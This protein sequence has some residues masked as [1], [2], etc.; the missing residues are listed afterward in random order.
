VADELPGVEVV[1]ALVGPV[2]L[3]QAEMADEV[4]TA[5]AATVVE[6]QGAAEVVLLAG[7]HLLAVEAGMPPQATPLTT[8]APTAPV[9]EVLAASGVAVRDG[10]EE[11]LRFRPL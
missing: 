11:A 5:A 9:P 3:A 8:K 10:S 1:T 2:E 4:E 7:S 6:V